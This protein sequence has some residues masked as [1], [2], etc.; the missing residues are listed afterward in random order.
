MPHAD[1]ILDESIAYCAAPDQMRMKR[2]R[3]HVAI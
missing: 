2:R 3:A 1:S